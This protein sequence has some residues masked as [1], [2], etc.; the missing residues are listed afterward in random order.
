MGKY[1]WP[2][3]ITPAVRWYL[4]L[5]KGLRQGVTFDEFLDLMA[6]NISKQSILE[7]SKAAVRSRLQRLVKNG[8]VHK[9][10]SATYQ[11]TDLGSNQLDLLAFFEL[12]L[13]PNY[14]WDGRWRLIMFDIPEYSRASRHT[15]RQLL[16]EL[17][18]KQLQ[19][20]VWIHPLPC[21]DQF[22]QIRHAY[23]IEDHLLLI[24]T[25][26]FNPP[27]V[28]VSHFG[29]KFPAINVS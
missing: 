24:E 25:H 13:A 21:L 17:G 15:I 2:S 7:Q 22:E 19:M 8:L 28:I 6:A 9:D 12:A 26:K 29:R 20:S 23:G 1:I 11:L 5:L 14:H 18:F 3:D 27:P 16:K 4:H 10:E